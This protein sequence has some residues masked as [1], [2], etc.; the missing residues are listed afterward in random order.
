LA[1]VREDGTVAELSSRFGVHANQIHAWKKTLLEGAAAL[2]A[3]GQGGDGQPLQSAST[4]L[5]SLRSSSSVRKLSPLKNSSHR[6]FV[7]RADSFPKKH[8]R[9]HLKNRTYPLLLY[10]FRPRL[11]GALSVISKRH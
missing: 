6:S 4:N 1:A 3:R 8:L 9:R 7:M 5:Y 2:F 10:R 11:S